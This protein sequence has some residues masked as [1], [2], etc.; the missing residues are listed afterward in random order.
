MAPLGWDEVDLH[1]SFHQQVK[2]HNPTNPPP[3]PPKK[4]HNPITNPPTNIVMWVVDGWDGRGSFSILFYF[5]LCICSLSL[6]YH[7]SSAPSSSSSSLSSV[8]LLTSCSVVFPCGSH[9][10]FPSLTSRKRT[11]NLQ[12]LSSH[13]SYTLGV[14]ARG[15]T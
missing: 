10:M 7:S 2:H 6:H 9:Y 12:H 11:N 14:R 13:N 1:E 8:A 3:P 15:R 4:R 5:I